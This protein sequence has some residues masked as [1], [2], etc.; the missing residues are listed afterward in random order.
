[1]FE[2]LLQP[3]ACKSLKLSNRFLMA[4]M[5]RYFAPGGT[6]GQDI[7][8]YYRRR[9]DGGVAGVITEGV[10]IDAPGSVAADTVPH[11]YG[12]R[13]L[14]G[15]RKVVEDVHAAG[16]AFIPQ[17]WHVGWCTD[18]NYPDS[19]HGELVSPSGLVGADMPGGR[20]MTDADIADVIAS[21][22]R[23]AEDAVAIGCDAIELHGAH[24]YLFDQFFWDVTNRRADGW[25]GADIAA[26]ARFAVETVKAIRRAVGDELAIIFRVSQWKV[27]DYDARLAR[28]PAELE[29]WL[30]PIADAGVD[31]F[32]ASERRFWEPTFE[33]SDR[34]LAGWIK[35]VTARPTITVGSI[36]L[37]RDLMAD[38]VEGT[39]HPETERLAD[40][41][42]RFDRGDFDLV[43]VGR[44][45]LSDPE[46]L[47]RVLTGNLA[48]LKPYN[49]DT[50]TQLY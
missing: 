17:L 33:G 28:D 45:L 26:R 12:E 21:F 44:A 22:A 4:P 20:E 31:I 27:Y 3:F 14:A 9:V 35:A 40:L 47:Q 37:S 16:G 19:P 42:R 5:S 36:G 1:M 8:D 24:G 41:E 13:A 39:S 48:A 46:W 34:N 2:T 6:P 32:H 43:A 49:L 18:F 38:F 25:G 15:W 30:T 11:F 29:A 23:A 7:A 10:A 50:K